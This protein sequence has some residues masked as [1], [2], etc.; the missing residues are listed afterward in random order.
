G[1][2]PAGTER[3]SAN[4]DVVIDR[5]AAFEAGAAPVVSLY[6]DT[7]PDQHGRER[8][9]AFVRKE[10]PARAESY[11]LR[12]P[13]RESLQ[14]D[15]E[16]IQAYLAGDLQPSANGVAIFACAAAG[17]FFDAVQLEAPIDEDQLYVDR[18]PHL[19]PLARV[20]DR[21]RRYA[22]VLVDTN[23]ARLFVFGVGTRLR[24]T[25]LHNVKMT[26]SAQGGWSQA[27]YQRHVDH[28]SAQHMKDVV[29]ALDRTV[30]ADAVDHVIVA[31]DEVAVP[32][33]REKLPKHLAQR[34][35]DVLRL[36]VGTP[37]HEVAHATLEAMR[38][39]DARDDRALVQRLL[40][41]FRAGGLGVVGVAA[42]L[43]A[44]ANG[45]VDELVITGDPGRVGDE[46]GPRGE[47]VANELVTRAR[48]TGARVTFVEDGALLAG[49]GGVGGL[50][51]FRIP[52]GHA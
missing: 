25:E 5:L 14:R 37:E 41:A 44:L 1:M 18:Q 19:Y 45:Q 29:D 17:D 24:E 3:R 38:G 52:G 49:V 48:Q 34:V 4:L 47:A 32:L 26:R 46:G 7:Q 40:D 28:H 27:R 2:S 12:S 30:R 16:R 51:R 20:N 43:A 23:T 31:G 8:W 6:L 10:L 36:D 15:I 33:L 9:G 21:Y 22:A 42:T 11:P 39:Q 35:V 50:L 13:E